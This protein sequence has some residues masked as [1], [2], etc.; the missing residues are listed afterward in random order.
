[1]VKVLLNGREYELPGEISLQQLV[2]QKGYN[3]ATIIVELNYNLVKREQ[4]GEVLLQEN[5][6][7]E[8]L[9]FVGGG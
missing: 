5:D 1:M 9:R 8:I 3:P 2:E 4:W 7:I 6:Q